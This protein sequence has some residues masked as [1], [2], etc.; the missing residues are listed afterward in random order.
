MLFNGDQR[1]YK[2]NFKPRKALVNRHICCLITVEVVKGAL[3][4]AVDVFR[5]RF[6]MMW[7]SMTGVT[8]RPEVKVIVSGFNCSPFDF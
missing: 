3:C 7:V 1:I 5:L 2:N 8:P 4:L 6:K